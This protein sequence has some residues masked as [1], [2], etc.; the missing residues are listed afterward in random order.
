LG[1]RLQQRLESTYGASASI[2]VIL[3]RVYDSAWQGYAS[4]RQ[5]LFSSADESVSRAILI[6]PRASC[7]LI[8]ADEGVR[9]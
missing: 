5:E 6:G 9:S 3:I 8:R 1:C 2:V 7:A 4:D